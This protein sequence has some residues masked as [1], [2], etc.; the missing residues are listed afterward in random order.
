M[1]P[2]TLA[3]L[4]FGFAAAL[5]VAP[6]SFAGAGPETVVA[7][8]VRANEYR[9]AQGDKLRIEVYKDPQLS[10]S[11][12]VRPDG[13]ITLPLVGDVEADGKTAI[14]LRDMVTEQ[15]K[16]FMTNPVV[17]VIVVETKPAVAYVTGEVNHPGAFSL[18]DDQLTVLQA[19]ALAGGLKDFANSKNIKILRKPARAGQPGQVT[20]FN[21]KDAIHGTAPVYLHAGDT[22]VVPD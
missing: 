20:D 11:V 15:L 17:T 22:V 7:G 1:K 16:T 3:S 6:P 12:Q 13:K 9:L 4:V 21:Y 5:S 14:Q 10:Q 18:Q 19:L 2:N 8:T